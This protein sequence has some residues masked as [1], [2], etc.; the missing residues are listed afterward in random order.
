VIQL[1][2]STRT[3][4]TQTRGFISVKTQ[5]NLLDFIR[6]DLSF[7]VSFSHV[8]LLAARVSHKLEFK[9][10]DSNPID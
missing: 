4:S 2:Q 5:H 1:N 9:I 10:S 8:I 6:R 7:G 3:E